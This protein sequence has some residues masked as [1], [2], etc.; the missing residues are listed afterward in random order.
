[1]Y[2]RWVAMLVCSSKDNKEVCGTFKVEIR[3][4]IGFCR[5][6]HTTYFTNV[7]YAAHKL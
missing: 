6:H 1:M 2:F 3:R 4:G 5:R 7:I